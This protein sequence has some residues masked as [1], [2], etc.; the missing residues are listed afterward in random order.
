MTVSRRALIKTSLA[1]GALLAA[2]AVRAQTT[3]R[4]VRFSLDWALQGNH[5]VFTMAIDRG[6][7]QREGLNVT[8]DRGAGSGDTVNRIASGAY[9]IGYT[10]INA[11]IPFNA[12]NPG[13]KVKAVFMVLDESQAAAC[14]L[15]S[16]NIA[17]PA[18][19][20]GKRIAAP[21]GEG[22]RLLFPAF[23]R[24]NNIDASSV[25]WV[26]VAPN[27]RE[28]VLAQ[29]QVDA[30]TGFVATVV[31]NLQRIGIGRDQQTVMRYNEHGVD[32]FGSCL[33]VSERYAQANPDIVRGF[34]R[35]C[36]AGMRDALANPTE[37][38]AQLKR[39]EPL[40]DEALEMQRFELV[41]DQMLLTA[42]IR[43]NGFSHVDAARMERATRTVAQAYNVQIRADDIWTDAFLPAAADRRVS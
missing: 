31:F 11:L 28:A 3:P 40:F 22:S 37:G 5:A 9:D 39:R 41:R 33:V 10:D 36:S 16:A 2:P 27:L 21:E 38:M 14:A 13:S 17:R 26:N 43:Q 8:M 34:V 32:I 19:F 15:R 6:H 1:G 12:A 7:M 18:D 30:I 24:A 25:T 35:A 29:R 4:N 20:A 42:N 23:A